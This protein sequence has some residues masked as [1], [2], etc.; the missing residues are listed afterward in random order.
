[1]NLG[2]IDLMKR[3]KLSLSVTLEAVGLTRK[4]AEIYT[5][6][7]RLGESPVADLIKATQTHPQ[8]VYSVLENLGQKKLIIESFRRNRKYVR[9]E[10]PHI[11]KRQTEKKLAELEDILPDLLRLQ[12]SSNDA[13]IRVDKG[14]EAVRR[15]RELA[16]EVLSKGDTFYILGGGAQGKFIEIMGDWHTTLERQRVRKGIIKRMLAFENQRE[17]IK[18]TNKITTI[19]E[20]RYLAE[21]YATPTSTFVFGRFVATVIWSGEPIVITIESREVA[22]GHINYFETLWK[23]AKS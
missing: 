9:A 16:L 15:V 3:R 6:L 10:D 13:I 11:L 20:T 21:N 17:L 18:R 1:M 5:A 14:N 19:T 7:L 22:E 12:R 4:E 8:I 23:M 2:F